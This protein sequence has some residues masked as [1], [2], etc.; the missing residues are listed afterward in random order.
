MS[1]IHL[2][3]KALTFYVIPD[4]SGSDSDGGGSSSSYSSLSD[5]VLDIQS[6]DIVGETPTN[7]AQRPLVDE[8]CVYSPPV[9]LVVPEMGVSNSDSALSAVDSDDV[10]SSEDEYNH[11]RNRERKAVGLQEVSV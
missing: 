8:S 9:E 3:I 4:E 5:F 10:S 7:L 6:S 11:H 1:I 2:F